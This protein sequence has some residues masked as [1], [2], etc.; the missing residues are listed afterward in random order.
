[1]RALVT[2]LSTIIIGFSITASADVIIS[3]G[4]CDLLLGG[5]I[6]SIQAASINADKQYERLNR[7]SAKLEALKEEL[8]TLNS[9]LSAKQKL[10]RLLGF[11]NA[12]YKS[13]SQRISSNISRYENYIQRGNA[14]LEDLEDEIEV[15]VMRYSR[16]KHGNEF[17]ELLA[18]QKG[19]GESLDAVQKYLTNLRLTRFGS[20]LTLGVEAVDSFTTSGMLSFLSS[21]LHWKLFHKPNKKNEQLNFQVNSTLHE[22]LTNPDAE[23][24]RYYYLAE[25]YKPMASVGV[26]VPNLMWKLELADFMTDSAVGK[27]DVFSFINILRLLNHLRDTSYFISQA[28]AVN[29]QLQTEAK[30][31]EDKIEAYLC[32]ARNVCLVPGQP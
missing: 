17:T 12:N 31:L 10:G 11:T 32:E 19:Y 14:R 9:G 29:T 26:H 21:M 1:M 20:T 25:D 30:I 15:G 6:K 22:N 24:L 3:E 13:D 16:L 4:S 18:L 8:K 27:L 23:E 7:A 28:N 2:I 5:T